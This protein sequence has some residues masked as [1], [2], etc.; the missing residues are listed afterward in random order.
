MEVSS[1]FGHADP[2]ITLKV[3]SHWIPRT[4][5][6]SIARLTGM[7][8]NAKKPAVAQDGHFLDTSKKVQLEEKAVNA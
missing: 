6:D 4:K 7:I 3:Y 5:T 2:Q 8:L 1:Y